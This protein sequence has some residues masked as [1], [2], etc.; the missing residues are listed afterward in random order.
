MRFI[1]ALLRGIIGVAVL[2]AAW[3]GVA[4]AEWL[5]PN[6][7][8]GP[9]EVAN[10]ARD[11]IAAD[12]F[13]QHAWASLD[14]L[15]Y[16]LLPALVL[17]ILIGILAGGSAGGCWLFGPFAMTIAAA[18]LVAAFPLMLLWFGAGL[19]PKIV[20]VFL[21]AA[22]SAANTVMVRWPARYAVKIRLAE[23]AEPAAWEARTPGRTCSVIAGLRVGIVLGVAA[24]VTAELIGSNVGLGYFVSMSGSLFNTVDAMAAA[25]II[26]LPTIA[27]GVFL[28]AIEEQLAG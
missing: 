9:V 23:P 2:G 21:V 20:F 4:A 12:A 19:V 22:F 25:L 18:P 1:G 16:G 26:L 27:A 13:L 5:P 3:W 10:K 8:P 28:Q 24:L 14:V 7:L 15:L 11:L 6:L 17:G